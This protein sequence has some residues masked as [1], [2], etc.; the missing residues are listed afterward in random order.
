MTYR[1]IDSLSQDLLFGGRIRACTTEQAYVF[2]DD[3]RPAFVA[4]AEELLRGS[5]TYLVFVNLVAAAPGL[6]DRAGEPPD[7]SL[8]RDADI[9]AAVQAAYPVVAGLYYDDQG[10]RF[11]APTPR[12]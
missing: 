4:L 5:G 2:K 12:P 6:S 9:L 7:Q 1:N 11:D 10:G 3:D 8:I